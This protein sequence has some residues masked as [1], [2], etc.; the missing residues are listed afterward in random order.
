MHNSPAI[1][2]ERFTMSCADNSVWL[3]SAMALACA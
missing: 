2:S 1:S 3:S